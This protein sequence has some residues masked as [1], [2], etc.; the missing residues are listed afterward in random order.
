MWKIVA[1]PHDNLKKLVQI[2]SSVQFNELIVLATTFQNC[3]RGFK[4]H[5]VK[6]ILEDK[7]QRFQLYCAQYDP[8]S[9]SSDAAL[10]P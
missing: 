7:D 1:K 4:R 9:A 10:A 6:E 5:L 3:R 2:L 8:S